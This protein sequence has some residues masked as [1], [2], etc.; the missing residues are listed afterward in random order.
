[1]CF[2]ECETFQFFNDCET[3]KYFKYVWEKQFNKYVQE[4]QFNKTHQIIKVGI[5][6]LKCNNWHKVRLESVYKLK[7][8]Y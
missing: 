2:D 7:S 8:D 4:K 3:C 6:T 1:M 5:P